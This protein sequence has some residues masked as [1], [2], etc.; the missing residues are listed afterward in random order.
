MEM[1]PRWIVMLQNGL[2]GEEL[3]AKAAPSAEALAGVCDVA[4]S[5]LAPATVRHFGH[6]LVHLAPL[7]RTPEGERAYFQAKHARS[8]EPRRG[9]TDRSR[10]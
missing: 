3:A 1:P 8:R 7:R 10:R 4:C 6:G 5:R 9:V 2:G